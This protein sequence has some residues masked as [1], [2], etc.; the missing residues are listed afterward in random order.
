MRRVKGLGLAVVLVLAASTGARAQAVVPGGWSAQ[1]G[2]RS[3][4]GGA[5]ANPTWGGYGGYGPSYGTYNGAAYGSPF[6]NY[7]SPA[8]G[9]RSSGFRGYV[10]PP[11]TVNQ[12]VPLGNSIGQVVG[13]RG[14]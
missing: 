2:Y 13:R 5:I 14:R 11:R 10:A 6:I 9:Y 4:G 3:L 1:V 8:S 12:I 7:G